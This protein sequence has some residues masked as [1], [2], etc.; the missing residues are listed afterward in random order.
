[1][2]ICPIIGYVFQYRLIKLTKAVGSFSIDICGILL[3]ANILRLNFRIFKWYQ[4]ALVFQS[5][6]M[7][8]M[9]VHTWQVRWFCCMSAR[10]TR[11]L[12]EMKT[13]LGLEVQGVQGYRRCNK[14]RSNGF[15]GG[16]DLKDIVHNK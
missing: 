10:N 2:A 15:G 6:F 14:R 12:R 3:F 7:I 9:Q 4:T 16:W 13:H 1:M 5:L 11:R 8:T